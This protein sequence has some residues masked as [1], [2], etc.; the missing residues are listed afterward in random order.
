MRVSRFA[1]A[2]AGLGMAHQPLRR[3]ALALSGARAPE[4]LS[5]APPRRLSSVGGGGVPPVGNQVAAIVE[6][7]GT[8]FEALVVRASMAEPP[9]TPKLEALVLAQGGAV[10][11][12]KLNVDNNPELAQSLQIKSLPTVLL[13]HK[14]K[15]VDQFTG[16]VTDEE[17]A[18]FVRKLA[19]GAASSERALADAA[20]ALEAGEVEKAHALY[21]AL[22]QLPE[23]A[24]DAAAGLALCYVKLGDAVQARSMA[25]ALVEH[26]K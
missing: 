9:L 24:A 1:R 14:G 20:I 18:A 11:L 17:L 25:A 15:L 8:T 6:V 13:V 5:H 10:R 2:F 12:A 7:D 16:V 3:S 26:F 4:L 19:G 23:A 21:S 22:G